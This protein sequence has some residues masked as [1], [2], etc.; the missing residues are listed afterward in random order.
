ML[1]RL[2]C[3]F[4]FLLLTALPLLLHD[5][6]ATAAKESDSSASVPENTSANDQSALDLALRAIT[7]IQGEGGFELWRLKAEWANIQKQDDKIFLLNPRLTYFMEDGSVMY[8]YSDS[9]DV[10]QKE[11]ILRFIDNVRVTQDDKIL[12]GKLLVHS[13]TAKTMTMS[14]GAEL[15]ATGMQGTCN[16]LVWYMDTKRIETAGNVVMHLNSVAPENRTPP[17]VET[18]TLDSMPAGQ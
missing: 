9:G 8:V 5:I 15:A 2:C 10:D 1:N 6:T 18:L 11:Q 13:G 7:L 12:T 4:F 17:D 16:H 14:E 3:I